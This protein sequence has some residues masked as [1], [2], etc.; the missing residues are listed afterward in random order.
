MFRLP[1]LRL[2]TERRDACTMRVTAYVRDAERIVCFVSTS[3]GRRKRGGHPPNCLATVAQ[4]IV[5]GVIILPDRRLAS[6]QRTILYIELNN[7]IKERLY[8]KYKRPQT[9][10]NIRVKI[11][12]TRKGR[13]RNYVVTL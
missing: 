12:K 4:R 6:S 8:T 9:T 13:F 10:R 2:H 11:D 5:P 3:L 7:K 1:F